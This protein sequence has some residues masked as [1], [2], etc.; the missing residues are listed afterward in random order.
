MASAGTSLSE[1]WR[2]AESCMWSAP[3]SRAK[4]AQSS[5]ARSGS[6]SRTDRGVSSW[7]AAVRTPIFMYLGA[8]GATGIRTSVVVRGRYAG[9]PRGVNH[10]NQVPEADTLGD[11]A[12]EDFRRHLAAEVGMPLEDPGDVGQV[13]L[14]LARAPSRIQ[15][16][17][18]L[19]S[20]HVGEA[21]DGQDQ[22]EDVSRRGARQEGLIPGVHLELHAEVGARPRHVEPVGEPL[23]RESG[24]QQLLDAR[25]LVGRDHQVEVEAHHR[26]GVGV[27]GLSADHAVPDLVLV[28]QT[29][30]TFEQVG[31]VHGHGLPELERLQGRIYLCWSIPAAPDESGQGCPGRPAVRW[32]AK[33]SRTSHTCGWVSR[34]ASRVARSSSRSSQGVR[35]ATVAVRG[36]PVKIETSPKKA[37]S[38]RSATRSWRPLALSLRKARTIPDVSMYRRSPGSPS[39]R[40]TSPRAKLRRLRP[41]ITATI[42]STEKSRKSGLTTIWLPPLSGAAGGGASSVGR[43]ARKAVSTRA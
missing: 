29:D 12:I 23:H 14:P 9:L 35:A 8:K 30:Q 17:P 16:R 4:A 28:E 32:R 42:T 24:L 37:P 43:G 25:E 13:F 36:P 21:G 39:R 2:A 7:S 6:G 41:W 40:M 15:G 34:I 33:S 18:D 38:L 26:F 1:G 22:S 19:A 31:S 3:T 27:D 20:Q 5:M 10:R 11:Q